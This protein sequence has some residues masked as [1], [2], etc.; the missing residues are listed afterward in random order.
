MKRLVLFGIVIFLIIIGGFLVV[1]KMWLHKVFEIKP[2]SCLIL[3]EKYCKM[4][5]IIYTDNEMAGIVYKIDKKAIL[6]SPM[7]EKYFSNDIYIEGENF[8][9]KQFKIGGDVYLENDNIVRSG[10]WIIFEGEVLSEFDKQSDKKINKGTIFGYANINKTKE[11]ILV[12][13]LS[14]AETIIVENTEVISNKTEVDQNK[15]NELLGK[16]NK[17]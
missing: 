11:V 16:N 9:R 2:G 10:Y 6:F 8:N 13:I 14:K 3:E 17:K 1:D 7:T 5:K 12:P 15:I 4:G